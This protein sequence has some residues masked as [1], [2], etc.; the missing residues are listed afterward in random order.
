MRSRKVRLKTDCSTDI[1]EKKNPITLYLIGGTVQVYKIS[2]IP[3][4]VDTAY[5]LILLGIIENWFLLSLA[6]SFF[7]FFFEGLIF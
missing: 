6:M 2:E 5:D 7:F 3:H 4:V 1:C